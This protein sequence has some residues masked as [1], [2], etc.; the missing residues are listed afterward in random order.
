MDNLEEAD[1]L[2]QLRRVTGDGG[3]GGGLWWAK[4]EVDGI[5]LGGEHAMLAFFFP[6][7]G[8]DV[9]NI[10]GEARCCKHWGAEQ[11]AV[12]IGGGARQCK[13]RWGSQTLTLEN[14]F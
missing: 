3:G 13:Q 11:D 6:A 12:N 10:G 14:S 2:D 8:T 4:A 9:V 1:S 5:Y 7:P